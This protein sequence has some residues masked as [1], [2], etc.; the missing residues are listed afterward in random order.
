MVSRIPSNWIALKVAPAFDLAFGKT[1]GVRV[2]LGPLALRVT[3]EAPDL[4]KHVVLAARLCVRMDLAA[5]LQVFELVL[6]HHAPRHHVFA[7]HALRRAAG[8]VHADPVVLL[9]RFGAH[10]LWDGRSFDLGLEAGH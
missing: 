7:D 4:R 9:H 6:Q 1:A 5:G 10:L 2:G 3:G 8:R